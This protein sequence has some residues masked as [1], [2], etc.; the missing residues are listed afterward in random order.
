MVREAG[1]GSNDEE[2]CSECGAAAA[3]GGAADAAVAKNLAAVPG[4]VPELPDAYLVRPSDLQQLKD[5]GFAHVGFFDGSGHLLPYFSGMLDVCKTKGKDCSPS[6]SR[7]VRL[8]PQSKITPPPTGHCSA[9]CMPLGHGD[10]SLLTRI[11]YCRE[12]TNHWSSC[13]TQRKNCLADKL[14]G[15]NN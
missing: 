2:G 10:T 13:F 4:T 11:A 9:L 14:G 5:V 15:L 6:L 8:L 12:I 7:L 1:G 3:G